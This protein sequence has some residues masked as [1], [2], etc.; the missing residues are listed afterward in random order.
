LSAS[1]VWRTNRKSGGQDSTADLNFP[2]ADEPLAFRKRY[3]VGEISL[4][5]LRAQQ[6]SG[7]LV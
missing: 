1:G 5:F 6:A 2:F 7:L 3:G 4:S